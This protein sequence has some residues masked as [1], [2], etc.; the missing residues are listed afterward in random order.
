M[1]WENE[2][3]LSAEQLKIMIRGGES[4]TVE[5]K[6]SFQKEVIETIVAFA[7]SEGGIVCLGVN[8]S[9]I[10]QGISVDEEKI[11]DWMN[12]IKLVTSPSLFPQ[13]N[14]IS[15]DN[16]SIVVITVQ[17]YPIKPVAYKGRY[18]KRHGASNHY[19]SASEIVELNMQSLNNS[20]DAFTTKNSIDTLSHDAL[21]KFALDITSSGRFKASDKFENDLDKLGF[22]KGKQ[23]T[24]A[25]ELLFGNHHTGIH[26]GRFKSR[27]V[28][29]DDI[30]IRSPLMLAI[31]EAMEFIKKISDLDL[32]L[33]V[34]L[35]V[36][37]NGSIH[38]L[39][40]VSFC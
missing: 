39:H 35:N 38:Y 27:H 29:I 13:C 19:L 3:N 24:R 15:V 30:M 26:I 1:K 37:K 22:I 28:I 33:L 32:N 14:I 34:S 11:K 6:T 8:N 16:K 10:I 31:D 4:S 7:N 17:E 21:D 5:F 2:L 23:V 12:K 40:Y 36:M 9:G 20:F 25:A 18:F